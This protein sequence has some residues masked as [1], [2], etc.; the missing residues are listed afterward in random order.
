[1][2]IHFFNP[3][4]F[5]P[6]DHRSPSTTGIGGSEV[7]FIELSRGLARRGHDVTCYAPIPEDTPPDGNI[8]WFDYRTA[9][10]RQP[11][12]W[13]IFRSPGTADLFEPAS[14]REAWLVCED[15]SYFEGCG[16][17]FTPERTAKFRRIMGLCPTHV[18][19]LKS[20]YSWMSDRVYLSSNGIDSKKIR[21]LKTSFDESCRDQKRIIWASSPDRGLEATLR[22]F[23]RAREF[24]PDLTLHICYGWKNLDCVIAKDPNGPAAKAKKKIFDLIDRAG[25][26]VVL[27]G[28]VNQPT[29]WEEMLKST[30]LLYPT[31]FPETSFCVGQEAQALGV[32]MTTAPLWAAGCNTRGGALIQGDPLSEPLTRA[33][34]VSAAVRFARDPELCSRIRN[35]TS[36]WAL[37]HFDWENVIS[38][39][40][41]FIDGDDSATCH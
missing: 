37:N 30:Q 19:W 38:Q 9:D 16:G 22:I 29:L 5:L 6:W 14:D 11:G 35:E 24:E 40:E 10:F 3:A 21:E 36:E 28:L 34:Y 2:D 12:L 15:V 13:I 17:A 41:K 39:Y 20:T 33:R 23:L 4:S 18:D 7:A 8:P 32:V 27:H 1:M 25:D 26:G 31:T